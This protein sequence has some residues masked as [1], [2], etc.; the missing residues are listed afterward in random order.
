YLVVTL[1]LAL[2]GMLA[3][4]GMGLGDWRSIG[5]GIGSAGGLAGRGGNRLVALLR[6]R[7]TIEDDT[8]PARRRPARS[9]TARRMAEPRFDDDAGPVPAPPRRRAPEPA[10]MPAAGGP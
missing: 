6:R 9:D 7:D 8:A 1:G 2:G 4:A 10:E 5:R 3:A